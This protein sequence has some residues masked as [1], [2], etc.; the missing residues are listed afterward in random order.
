MTN[1]AQAN[2]HYATSLAKMGLVKEVIASED[3]CDANGNKLWAKGKAIDARLWEKLSN[4]ALKQPLEATVSAADPLDHEDVAETIQKLLETK[5]HFKTLIAPAIDPIL[6]RIKVADFN[7]AELVMLSLLRH[8]ER[9]I[10]DHA[11]AVAAAAMCFGVHG[12]LPP[13]DMD[14]LLHAGMLHDVGEMYLEPGLFS[15]R[16]LSI[17]DQ[18]ELLMHPALGA[19]VTRE[20]LRRSSNIFHAIEQSHERLDGSGYASGLPGNALTPLALPLLTAE[21]IIGLLMADSAGIQHA[22]IALRLNPGEFPAPLVA[23]VNGLAREASTTSAATTQL[24]P[25]LRERMAH[26][27]ARNDQ[28][29][30]MLAGI[31]RDAPLSPAQRTVIVRA[32]NIVK[33]CARTL[34][35]TGLAQLGSLTDEADLSIDQAEAEATTREI[36]YRLGAL[37][38][39]I[40]VGFLGQRKPD[41]IEDLLKAL[42]PRR[43]P[44]KAETT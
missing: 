1:Y 6:A 26:A 41:A 21:A 10:F 24:E 33:R 30:T 29:D 7:S 8:G 2:Q 40:E 28:A 44:A 34:N 12:N 35:S 31:L 18:R 16:E 32:Q 5:P 19:M 42:A 4:R 38:R 39:D 27:T 13:A 25:A 37:V 22:A 3:I 11:C 14:R 36:E 43:E 9:D 23:L 20:V 15:R 17:A